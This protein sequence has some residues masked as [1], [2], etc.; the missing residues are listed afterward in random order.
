[1][2]ELKRMAICDIST[3]TNSAGFTKEEINWI[4]PMRRQ[5]FEVF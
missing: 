1:M 2:D 3:I 5:A 4:W